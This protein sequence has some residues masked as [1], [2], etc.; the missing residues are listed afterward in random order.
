MTSEGDSIP[1]APTTFSL[2][3]DAPIGG[4]LSA[5]L[6]P[7]AAA[8]A[9]AECAAALAKI[10]SAMGGGSFAPATDSPRPLVLPGVSLRE[11]IN[12]MLVTKAR[13]GKS[14][15]YLRQLRVSLGSAAKHLGNPPVAQITCQQIERWLFKQDWASR[16]MRGYLGDVRTLLSFAIRRGYVERDVSKGVELPAGVSLK[17]PAIH[18]PEQVSLVLETARARDPDIMRHL[19]VRYFCGVRSAEA[20]RMT[21]ANILEDRGYVEVPA[22]KSKTRRRRLVKIQPVLSAWLALGGSLR[23]IRPDTIR[24]ATR[25]SGVPWPA[26][27]TRHSFVSYHLA[28]FE[29][30]GKTALEAGHSEAMLFAHYRELVT[31]EQAEAFFGLFPKK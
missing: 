2:K 23:P 13:T 7:G 15:R 20:H 9:L 5:N 17:P 19:A 16:T 31:K 29:N 26:N 30:A 10:A 11:V 4:N 25:A 8:Q 27:V 24:A 1:V 28:S 12:E 3:I 21:D 22:E 14:D 18:T 6:S